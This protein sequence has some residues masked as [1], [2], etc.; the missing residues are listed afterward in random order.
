ME[1]ISVKDRL[2]EPGQYVMLCH[3]Y[4]SKI[5]G[6]D[7]Y[8][9]VTVGYFHQ[10]T[11]RRCRPYFYYVGVNDYGDIVRASS[12]CPGSEHVTHWMPMPEPPKEDA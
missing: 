1:W 8:E 6:R 9:A 10:P 4:H 5:S 12:M 2:P 11:D 3:D 7:E